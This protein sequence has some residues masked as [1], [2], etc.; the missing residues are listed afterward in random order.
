MTVRLTSYSCKLCSAVTFFSQAATRLCGFSSNLHPWTMWNNQIER[1]WCAKRSSIAIVI[2]ISEI[3]I[4]I[5]PLKVIL[6]P[7]AHC[8]YNASEILQYIFKW[9]SKAI[10]YQS[11]IRVF[12]SIL[13]NASVVCS[14]SWFSPAVV[15]QLIT[16]QVASFYLT[17]RYYLR[18]M[19][20]Q[21]IAINANV[22]HV[23][24]TEALEQR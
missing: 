15:L 8:S 1:I 21:I 9:P 17:I 18:Y 5:L 14:L 24:G 13:L 23:G 16:H 22:L 11:R 7:H 3:F 19:I 6:H 12:R 20:Y 4:M 2:V 10:R